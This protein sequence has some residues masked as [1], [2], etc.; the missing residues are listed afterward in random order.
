M[1]MTPLR[2]ALLS[3]L[4]LFG[5]HFVNRRLDRVGLIGVLLTVA[6]IG[7]VGV[8]RAMPFDNSGLRILVWLPMG[9]LILVGLIALVSAR[10]TFHDAPE[11]AQRPPTLTIRVIRFPVTLFGALT[12][13]LVAAAGIVSFPYLGGMHMRSTTRPVGAIEFGSSPFIGGYGMLF[14]AL[15]D[16]P[17]GS[18][19]LRGRIS[20][21]G[22]GI[23][24]AHISLVI[25]DQYEAQRLTSDSRGVFEASLPAG[26]W[27]VNGLTVDRW[28]ERPKDR[29]LILFSSHEPLEGKDRYS[30][31]NLELGS[32]IEVILPERPDSIPIEVEF[33]D[34]LSLT[35][36]PRDG[37]ANANFA[38]AAIAWQPVSN[39]AEYEVQ[40]CNEESD[41]M[42]TCGWSPALMRRVSSTSLPLA[43]LP[44]RAAKTK[45]NKYFVHVFA[46]DAQGHLLTESG[47]GGADRKFEL[48]GATRLGKEEGWPPK[49]IT[50]EFESNAKRL[51]QVADLLREKRFDDARGVLDQVTNDAEPGRATALRGRLAALLGDCVKAKQ[52][53][54]QAEKEGACVCAADRQ[55]CDRPRN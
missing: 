31:F 19:R 45:T 9:L 51:D 30:R 4:T 34:A 52:L 3:G 50:E 36:P 25:N 53:F 8:A 27:R 2:R 15:L 29:D 20:L 28:E 44:Q 37:A 1:S 10:L 14:D 24:G 23:P 46:F 21:Q 39:A 16:A 43:A 11:A 32:G 13:A 35:W 47:G 18:E 26:K 48:T 55:L 17:S 41:W 33:R 22:V 12:L 7:T 49:V 54:D 42:K 5:G 40:I 38:T 6:V